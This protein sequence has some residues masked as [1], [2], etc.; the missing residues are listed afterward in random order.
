MPGKL[1]IVV[2]PFRENGFILSMLLD[3][4]ACFLEGYV[5]Q[6]WAAFRL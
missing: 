4:I 1:E 2:D 5:V 6:D 3:L